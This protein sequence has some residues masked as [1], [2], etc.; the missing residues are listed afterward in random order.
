MHNSS[1]SSFSTRSGT[2]SST[3]ATASDDD[4]FDFELS[5][6]DFDFD[7]DDYEYDS[8]EDA[9]LYKP[10]EAEPEMTA[11]ELAEYKSQLRERLDLELAGLDTATRRKRNKKL[12]LR[13]QKLLMW[14][15]S[16][17]HLQLNRRQSRHVRIPKAGTVLAEY[18][19]EDEDR[20]EADDAYYGTIITDKSDDTD[21]EDDSAE[22]AAEDENASKVLSKADIEAAVLEQVAMPEYWFD[23][24]RERRA[25]KLALLKRRGKG[26]PKKGSGK[27]SK[28]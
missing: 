19:S 26:P 12:S 17:N 22:V 15:N 20:E 8:D 3:A 13:G 18:L 24:K 4:E 14:K 5:D 27:R 9:E 2:Q 23:E 28:K 10:K 11:A 21:G 6:D 25:V 7:D 16:V 1:L